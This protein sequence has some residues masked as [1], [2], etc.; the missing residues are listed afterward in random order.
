M[1]EMNSCDGPADL[2]D[3]LWNAERVL[4]P[5]DSLYG[6]K[7]VSKELKKMQQ[8]F[9]E[10]WNLYCLN[11]CLPVIMDPSKRLGC[12]KSC[13]RPKLYDYCLRHEL[14][15]DI[16]EYF[17]EVHDTLI[18]LFYEYSD[19]CWPRV[20]CHSHGACAEKDPWFI[21][22]D[23]SAAEAIAGAVAGEEARRHQRD[24]VGGWE[25]RAGRC[26]VPEPWFIVGVDEPPPSWDPVKTPKFVTLSAVCFVLFR[27]LQL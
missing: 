20:V 8:K 5:E 19:Q 23:S 18:N 9:T 13:L 22:N 2:L 27:S 16:E 1:D 10:Y 11:I 14:D 6:D 3:R 15:K 12:I 7:T 4:H 21:V 24:L 26:E 17:Q 25:G